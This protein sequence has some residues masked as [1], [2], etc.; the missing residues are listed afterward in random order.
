MT[1]EEDLGEIQLIKI[2][3]RK[4]WYQDDWYLKYVTVKTPLGDYLE[5]PCYRW[6]TDEKEIVL[7]DG[8]GE[9]L[10][11]PDFLWS[12][13][14]SPTAHSFFPLYLP[15]FSIMWRTI[16]RTLLHPREWAVPADKHHFLC[17][18]GHWRLSWMV[19]E[20]HARERSFLC[21]VCWS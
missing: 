13:Q 14:N 20:T 8:R 15:V 5:F 21:S 4:Y 2:E 16:A 3:K 9:H 11:K 12:S 10:K 17:K 18:A 7:R 1:V 6:I 19:W